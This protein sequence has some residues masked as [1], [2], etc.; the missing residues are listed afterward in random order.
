MSV[1]VFAPDPAVVASAARQLAREGLAVIREVVLPETFQPPLTDLVFLT[2]GERVEVYIDARIR[3]AGKSSIWQQMAAQPA[4]PGNARLVAEAGGDLRAAWHMLIE[5]LLSAGGSVHRSTWSAEDPVDDQDEHGAASGQIDLADGPRRVENLT[6]LAEVRRRVQDPDGDRY[7]DPTALYQ[8]LSTAVR[9]QDEAL[10]TLSQ[11]ATLHVA[12]KAPRRPATVFAVGPTGVGKTKTA[13]ELAGALSRVGYG[14]CRL[15]M[16]E[17]QERHRVSQLLGA[18]QGYLGYGD[19]SQLVD[20]LLAHP[21]TVVLFDE[22][23]KAHPEVLR[24]LMNAMDAG[25]LSTA[26]PAADNGREID[27]RR[28]IFIF[29]SNLDATGIQR[30][31]ETRQ[32]FGDPLVVNEVC[33]SRLRAAGIA[34]ELIGRISEFLVFRPLTVETRAEIMAL[35]IAAVAQDYGLAVEHIEPAVIAS[36]LG[37][38]ESGSLGVRPDEYLVDSLLGPAFAQ[39][40]AAGWQTVEVRAGPPYACLPWG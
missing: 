6:D 32:G 37:R 5:R 2:A 26:A 19:G 7:L 11:R 9:G 20:A 22:I 30:D 33:R 23:E 27:C 10:R 14:Y 29:T 38:A 15:D 3:Y 25:R 40:A 28:A 1:N 31:L 12:R 17:Y 4:A 34:P 13:E 39:S 35:V 18:P 24:A 16:A 8:T 21:R 36:L